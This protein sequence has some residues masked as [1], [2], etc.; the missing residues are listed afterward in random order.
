MPVKTPVAEVME[1]T[2][3]LRLIQAPPDEPSVITV[4]APAHKLAKP[5]IGAGS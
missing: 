3:G 2:D 1:P 5:D 4:V